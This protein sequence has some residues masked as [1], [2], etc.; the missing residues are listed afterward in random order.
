[1]RNLLMLI[2][3]LFL[4]TGLHAAEEKTPFDG[5]DQAKPLLGEKIEQTAL[6]DKLV[7]LVY[8]NVDCPLCTCPKRGPFKELIAFQKKNGNGNFTILAS[9]VGAREEAATEFCTKQ[10]VNF[11]VLQRFLSPAAPC[12]GTPTAVLIDQEGKVVAQ[13]SPVALL[14]QAKDLLKKN[15]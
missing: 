14:K 11:P 5:I 10:K 15:K 7:L 4:L 3:S 6:K 9:H 2:S 13:G 1:M 8:W 12:H